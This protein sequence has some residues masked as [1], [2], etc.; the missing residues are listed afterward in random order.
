VTGTL[1]IALPSWAHGSA[2]R[3]FLGIDSI[4]ADA[5]DITLSWQ[6]P[7]PPWAIACCV[8]AAGTAAWLTYRA[9]QASRRAVVTLA[10]LRALALLALVA[11]LAG[12]QWTHMVRELERDCVVVLVDRSRS[13]QVTDGPMSRDA[14]AQ[15]IVRDPMWERLAQERSLEWLGFH[16][17]PV[18]FD[19]RSPGTPEGWATDISAALAAAQRASG[20]RPLAG[21]VLVSDGR[22]QAPVQRELLRDLQSKSIPV[23]SVPVG[24]ADPV[25]DIAVTDAEGP[26]RAFVRDQVPVTAVVQVRG[27]GPESSMVIELVDLDSG[28]VL[29]ARTLTPGEFADGRVEA[30]LVSS[31][32]DAGRARWSVR[33][34][35]LDSD[36]PRDL[37]PGNDE[38]RVDVE[39]VDRPLRVLYI[40]GYP[41]WEYRYLKNLLVREPSVEASVMLLSA[42]RDFAQEGNAPLYRLPQTREE[43]SAYDLIILGDVP[44]GALSPTQV[45]EIAT[46]VSERGAGLLWLAGERS[47]PVS[48][49]GSALEDL[50]PI[51]IGSSVERIDEPVAL[52][53]TG[54][55][56]RAGVMR[57]GDGSAEW[58]RSLA[59]LEWVQRVDAGQL[60]PA[61]E[62]LARAVGASAGDGWPA[63]LS[64]RFGSGQV[65]YV[66]TD[67]T[68]RWRRG[69]GETYQERFWLQLLRFLARNSVDAGGRVAVLESDARLVEAG[70]GTVLRLVMTDAKV[71][72]AVGDT[73]VEARAERIDGGASQLIQLRRS[74]GA[75]EAVWA[76]TWVPD[77]PGVWRVRVDDSRVGQAE[78]VIES[79]RGDLESADPSTD[80]A[81]LKAIADSTGGIVIGRDGLDA[82][83]DLIPR[84]ASDS[85]QSTTDPLT[86]SPAAL[87]VII[88]LL[89]A[90]WIG[91]R[92]VRLA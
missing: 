85:A 83:P 70:R 82:I 12:P 4:P 16:G 78:A 14:A 3:W 50:V 86:R 31:P 59:Q 76:A 92:A 80:H 6:T 7:L 22:S 60:K 71:A 19:P 17:T 23:L 87:G 8:L 18:P 61:T 64:M 2:W 25:S 29:D 24:S 73:P 47:T 77:E 91:R 37:S 56:R 30:T 51:R 69:V 32:T 63:V 75:G 89:A 34:R 1:A 35:P 9:L 45:S 39:L 88:L 66:G 36:G 58:P 81:Q 67:E 20:G 13:M 90:E 57:L 15:E 74:S 54:A 72:E 48:W 11:C 52:E 68:W 5:Q 62:V 46:A 49:R 55:A 79:V 43:F 42:D 28:R 44:A 10:T 27:R 40:E 41:R 84:R 26:A 33:V 38:R 21:I 65:I 53:P